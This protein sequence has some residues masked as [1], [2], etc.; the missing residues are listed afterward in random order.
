MES[1]GFAPN[2]FRRDIIWRAPHAAIAFL[3]VLRLPSQAEVD[4]LGFAFSVEQ[5]VERLDVAMEEILF[6]RGIQG[7]RHLNSDIEH[8]EFGNDTGL[9]DAAVEAA[10]VCKLHHQ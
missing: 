4:K 7:R 6:E 5:N 1:L 9:L 3:L 8:R 10:I 2:F